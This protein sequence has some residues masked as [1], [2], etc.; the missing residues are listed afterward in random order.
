MTGLGSYLFGRSQ[1][2]VLSGQASDCMNSFGSLPQGSILAPLLFLIFLN[3]IENDIQS[4]ISFFA[5]DVSLFKNFKN[6]I[7][8]EQT[9]NSDL[10][11]INNWALKWGMEFNPSKTEIMIFSNN[12]IKSKP[13]ITF[14]GINL[15]Q[16]PSHEHLGIHLSEDMHWTVHINNCTKKS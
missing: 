7:D 11:T 1:R 4:N 3:D 5:D 9:L 16:V 2:V 10:N 15:K 8:L 12:K 6:Y 13:N 14:K